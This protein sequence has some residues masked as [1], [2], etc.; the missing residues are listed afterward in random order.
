[1]SAFCISSP[2]CCKQNACCSFRALSGITSRRE[3]IQLNE[4]KPNH[5]NQLF[6]ENETG[7]F[8]KLLSCFGVLPIAVLEISVFVGH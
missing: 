3:R 7:Y 6:L 1:V 5:S 8:L 4:N 2:P